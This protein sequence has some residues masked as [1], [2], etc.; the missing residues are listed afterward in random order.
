MSG[1]VTARRPN[2]LLVL[3]DQQRWDHVG[4]NGNPDV[5]TP[6]LD[7]LAATGRVLSRTHVASPTC[8]PNRA[9][10]L[11]SRSPSAHGLRVNGLALDP[12]TQTVASVFRAAGYRTG[13]VG[14]SHLQPYGIKVDR[15]G[16]SQPDN[17]RTVADSSWENRARHD[18]EYVR[19][20]E[21]YYGFSH[22]ELTIGHGSDVSGH[23][24]HWLRDRGVE[25]DQIR[26]REQS[27]RHTSWKEQ[28]AKAKR[29]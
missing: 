1:D 4:F 19:M 11:T 25:P 28:Q 18:A 7:G 10:L 15:P 21:D 22:V 6:V 14:K 26:G 16:Q 5:A 3:T 13:L 24:A 20:P 2:V 17:A 9:S 29:S 12:D 27:R 8:A 23:Y